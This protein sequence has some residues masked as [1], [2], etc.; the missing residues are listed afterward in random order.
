MPYNDTKHTNILT[1]E[2]L[3]QQNRGGI[4]Y[5]YAGQP[6]TFE[7]FKNVASFE[8]PYLRWLKDFNITLLPSLVSIRT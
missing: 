3:Q 5:T 2:Y 7:P 1:Q 4:T 6:K 8:A